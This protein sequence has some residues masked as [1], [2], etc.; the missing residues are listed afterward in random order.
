LRFWGSICTSHWTLITDSFPMI[1]QSDGMPGGEPTC[2]GW[3]VGWRSKTITGFCS[4]K[5]QK[6]QLICRLMGITDVRWWV[7]LDQ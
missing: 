6:I 3:I 2:Q 5:R 1:C 7:D 4:Q